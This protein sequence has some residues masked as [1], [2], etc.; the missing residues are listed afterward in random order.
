MHSKWLS[1]RKNPAAPTT[2]ARKRAYP[3]PYANKIKRVEILQPA[4]FYALGREHPYGYPTK[5]QAGEV[6]TRAPGATPRQLHFAA[7]LVSFA[8]LA[9]RGEIPAPNSRRR[10]LWILHT[11]GF[12]KSVGS[13][14]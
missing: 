2:P 7:H 8:C 13:E 12:R 6:N 4:Q 11:Y 9:R 14:R 1:A 10:L 3:H 5:I